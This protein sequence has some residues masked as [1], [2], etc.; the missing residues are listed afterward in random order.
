MELDRRELITGAAAS[1]VAVAVPLPAVAAPPSREQCEHCLGSWWYCAEI[2]AWDDA[3]NKG[4]AR[5]C[6][7]PVGA[8]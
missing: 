6:P 4:D 1:L 8:E 5:L 7:L 2:Q 3:W